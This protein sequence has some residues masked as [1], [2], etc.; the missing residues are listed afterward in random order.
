[1]IQLLTRIRFPNILHFAKC[2]SAYKFRH[3]HLDMCRWPNGKECWGQII[4]NSSTHAKI[5]MARVQY[6]TMPLW[7]HNWRIPHAHATSQVQ[8]LYI[9][10]CANMKHGWRQYRWPIRTGS[11]SPI[12]RVPCCMWRMDFMFLCCQLLIANVVLSELGHTAQC[13]V[14]C[15]IAHSIFTAI[16]YRTQIVTIKHTLEAVPQTC[17]WLPTTNLDVALNNKKQI[18]TRQITNNMQ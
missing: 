1:M 8:E 3:T 13:S 6:L 11:S 14:H 4:L 7:W 12:T 17:M 9:Q 10:W 16:F 18:I 5:I 2:Y 15:P